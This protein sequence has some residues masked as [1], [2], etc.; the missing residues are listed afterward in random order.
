MCK[1]PEEQPM[2][3]AEVCRMLGEKSPIWGWW[4]GGRILDD[5]KYPTCKKLHEKDSTKLSE[6]LRKISDRVI[7]YQAN[8]EGG[9]NY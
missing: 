5:L 4:A 7:E 9:G 6:N 2:H 3:T 8:V 1:E